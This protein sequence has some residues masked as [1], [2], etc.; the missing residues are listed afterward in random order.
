MR[1]RER[2]TAVEIEA[3]CVAVLKKLPGLKRIRYAR[4]CPYK[5]SKSWTWEMYEAGPDI[6]E[7]AV[8]DAM[9]EINRLQSEC[10]LEAR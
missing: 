10:D 7:I 4:I 8:R 2:L 9:P 5:G 3:R 6:G 1:E